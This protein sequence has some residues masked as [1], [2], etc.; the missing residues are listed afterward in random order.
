[1]RSSESITPSALSVM[2]CCFSCPGLVSIINWTI[3]GFTRVPFAFCPFTTQKSPNIS[4]L[5]PPISLTTSAP[6]R[7]SGSYM[8][9]PSAALAHLSCPSLKLLPGLMPA[10]P[11]WFMGRVF[12][13]PF[14]I[15]MGLSRASRLFY[16]KHR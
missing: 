16:K 12:A 1:M 7:C 6:S 2:G 13:F 14:T 11:G 10:S 9:P 4:Y 5:R 8:T 3:L 15:S